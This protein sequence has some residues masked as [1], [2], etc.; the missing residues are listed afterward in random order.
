MRTHFEE[1][2]FLKKKKNLENLTLKKLIIN[3]F[4]TN[5]N[6]F[7]IIFCVVSCFSNIKKFDILTRKIVRLYEINVNFFFFIIL[8]LNICDI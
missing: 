5:F 3:E 8:N 7:M 1:F 6:I 2:F 4:I